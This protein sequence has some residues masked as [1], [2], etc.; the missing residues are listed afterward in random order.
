MENIKKLKRDLNAEFDIKDL[1]RAKKI[2]G[3]NIVRDRIKGK[4]KI[5]Q[6]LYLENS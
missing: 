4:L 5:H 1:G 2:L 6:K 3:M